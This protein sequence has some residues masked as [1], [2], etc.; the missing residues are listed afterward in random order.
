MSDSGFEERPDA[1]V[2][3]LADVVSR[4][5]P[6]AVASQGGPVPELAE[7]LCEAL[8]DDCEPLPRTRKAGYVVVHLYDRKQGRVA[9]VES[10][11]PP[12]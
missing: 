2:K 3:W 9:D 11:E 12:V 4:R 7:R 10:W 6:V 1:A 8:G 5:S